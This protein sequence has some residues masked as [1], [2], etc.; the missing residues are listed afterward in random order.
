ME[1]LREENDEDEKSNCGAES[2]KVTIVIELVNEI[3]F[4]ICKDQSSRER[5]S[6]KI[7]VRYFIYYDIYL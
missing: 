4:L 3:M 7:Q 6:G 2:E 5:L 1:H